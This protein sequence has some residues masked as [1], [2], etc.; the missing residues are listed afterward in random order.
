MV[1]AWAGRAAN[2]CASAHPERW[3]DMARK[4]QEKSKQSLAENNSA[5][6]GREIDE[7]SNHGWLCANGNLHAGVVLRCLAC[8]C[9]VVYFRFKYAT[10]G[11]QVVMID[12]A[13]DPQRPALPQPL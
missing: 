4:R 11:L 7:F 2:A 13:G 12:I 9:G 8:A 3:R 5:P 6:S 1:V 10:C